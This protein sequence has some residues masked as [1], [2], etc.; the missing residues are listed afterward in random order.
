MVVSAMSGSLREPPPRSS[1][2]LLYTV[3]FLERADEALLPACYAALGATFGASPSELGMLTSARAALQ[4]VA[5]LPAGAAADRGDRLSVA[6]SACAGWGVLSL[7]L[8]LAPAFWLVALLRGL[9]GMC[10]AAALPATQAVLSDTFAEEG[11]GRAF[12]TLALIASGGAALAAALLAPL[13]TARFTLIAEA[14]VVEGWRVAFAAV[15]VASVIAGLA[16]R[17]FTNKGS[18]QYAD[19]VGFN[20][21]WL[22]KLAADTVRDA[23]EM[24]RHKTL[25]VVC[26][27]GAV[28]SIPWKGLLFLTMYLQQ[29]GFGDTYAGGITGAFLA[30]NA[31]GSVLGGEIS[32]TWARW[33]G[34]VVGRVAA[35]QTSVALGLPFSLLLF[36]WLPIPFEGADAESE[37]WRLLPIY[38][39][40]TFTFALGA[41]WCGSVNNT[42]MS[43]VVLP[44]RR[45]AIFSFDRFFEGIVS[46]FSSVVVGW[47][48]E[49]SGWRRDAPPGDAANARAL[50]GAILNACLAPWC[51]CFLAYTL[52]Y[53]TFPSD[54]QRLRKGKMREAS[55]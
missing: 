29:S 51:L 48:A 6:G 24:A 49:A 8:A 35:A 52:L 4:A 22:R 1:L 15:G 54:L 50:G 34:P 33:L 53:R 36:R 25:Q 31:L 3:A 43:C 17:A 47:M 26:A 41:S 44:E 12:G 45:C 14:V 13:S 20:V 42:I 23:M 7:L 16:L 19:G 46:S 28:G 18:Y 27:Q 38:V 10:L 37:A 11:R 2:P 55:F 21:R 9:T 30:G 32:D 40:T 5:C 39:A